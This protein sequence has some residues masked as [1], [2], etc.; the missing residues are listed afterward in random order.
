MTFRPDNDT[1]EGMTSL[2]KRD[3][4]PFSEQIRRALR[5]WLELK[6]AMK[7]ETKGERHRKRP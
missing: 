5:S 3:G 2:R 7:P 6:G 4:I 1:F